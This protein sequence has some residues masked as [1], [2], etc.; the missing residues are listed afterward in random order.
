MSDQPQVTDHWLTVPR[1]DRFPRSMQEPDP[2]SRRMHAGHHLVN[3]QAPTRPITGRLHSPLLMSS[4]AFRHFICGSLS[5][6]FIGSYPTRSQARL[7]PQRSAPTALNRRTLGW[8]VAPSC[9]ATTEGHRDNHRPAPP[10]LAQHRIENEPIISSPSLTGRTLC[11]RGA[12]EWARFRPTA[13]FEDPFVDTARVLILLDTYD[14]PAAY[15]RYH[16]WDYLA[17]NL[18][19][20]VWFHRFNPSCDWLLIDHECTLADRGLMAVNGRVWYTGGRLLATGSAQLCCVPG[21]Q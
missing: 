16:S 12:R 2:R 14:F 5:F 8:F 18:D 3:K 1:D 19:T 17:P 10:S 9:K 7:F 20:S 6:A 15:Q 4:S 13:C 21:S 11:A